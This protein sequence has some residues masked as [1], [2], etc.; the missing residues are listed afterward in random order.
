MICE[1]DFDLATLD[2][3][4]G[5]ERGAV[6]TLLHPVSREQLPVRIW[7]QGTDAPAYRAVVRRQID[8]Q[9]A[10]GKADLSAAELEERHIQRLAAIT[11]KWEQV[12]YR[13][14][15]LDCTAGNA[16]RLYREQ[17]WVREQVTRFTEDRSRF[18]DG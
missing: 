9:I 5:A 13:G 4:A 7:L 12:K 8:Q 6:L 3:A 17:V 14:K 10:D 1:T 2:V 11:L 15:N 18:L 16:E